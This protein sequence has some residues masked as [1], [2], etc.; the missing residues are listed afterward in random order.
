MSLHRLVS[1]TLR[2]AVKGYEPDGDELARLPD[3]VADELRSAV[4]RVASMA[5]GGDPGGADAESR[6][7]VIEVLE[8]AAEH[9]WPPTTPLRPMTVDAETVLDDVF[10]SAAQHPRF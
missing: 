6:R 10:L 5:D 1:Q 8:F 2:A 9:R 7:S 3:E 4:A